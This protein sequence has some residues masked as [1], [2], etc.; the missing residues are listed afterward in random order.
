MFD[1]MLAQMPV[2]EDVAFAPDALANIP[3]LR[4]TT[5][6]AAGDSALLYLHGGGYIIGNAQGYRVLA[7]DLG[8]AAGMTVFAVDYRLAPEHPFP[9]AV[10]DAV[11]AY[12]A[13]IARGFDPARIVLAGDSAGGGLALAAL[14]ALRDRGAALPAAALLISPWADLACEGVSIEAKAAEDPSLTA[15]GLRA[16]AAHYV[17]E[18]DLKS[19][20]A[21]PVYSNLAGLPP[22]L[23]QVGSAEIL[24]DDALRVARAA[25]AAGVSVR[26]EVWSNMVHVWHAFAF[27]LR[28]GRRAIDAAGR[29]LADHVRGRHGES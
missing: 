26:L 28:E 5:P 14:V 8:R 6:G 9:A 22:L 3:T 16:A 20:L 7:A 13:L 17:R 4:I 21:S 29:F 15:R 2:S 11:A 10:E 27:M 24:F 25:G 19:P 1:A 23:I 18:A 12:Q